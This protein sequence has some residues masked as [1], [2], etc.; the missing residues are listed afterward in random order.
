MVDCTGETYC[1]TLLTI[2]TPE[3]FS[4]KG[5][6]EIYRLRWEIEVAYNILTNRMKLEVF[7][8]KRNLLIRQLIY[9]RVW[10]YNLIMLYIY[11][12]KINEA[13]QIPQEH[14]KY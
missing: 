5:L 2:L 4:L 8:G 13:K 1:K 6:K 7:S 9:Y 12:I 3:E 10:L 11:I 14:Y